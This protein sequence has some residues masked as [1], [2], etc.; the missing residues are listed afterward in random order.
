MPTVKPEL[1]LCLALILSG[2]GS[3][4]STTTSQPAGPVSVSDVKFS[5]ARRLVA[6]AHDLPQ[7]A[8]YPPGADPGEHGPLTNI[9]AGRI[10][11]LT[12][13]WADPALFKSQDQTRDFLKEILSSTNTQTWSFHI[14][15]YGDVTPSVTATVEHVNGRPGKWWIWC[16]PGLAWAYLDANG[17]WWWGSWGFQSP[18]PKSLGTP[19]K[20]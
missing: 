15:S 17:K 10:S 7:E 13:T 14:W 16:S 18:K 20:S 4:C 2:A 1:F 8:E 9:V 12:V 3:G 11:A 5:F 19:D 6:P